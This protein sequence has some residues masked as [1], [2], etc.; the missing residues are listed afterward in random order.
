MAA[1]RNY[2]S[3]EVRGPAR[4][5]LLQLQGAAAAGRRAEKSYS[6]FKVRRGGGEKIPLIPGKR[7]PRKTVGVVRGHQRAEALKP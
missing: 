7:N 2:P 3:P 5:E 6:T 4:E 1:E